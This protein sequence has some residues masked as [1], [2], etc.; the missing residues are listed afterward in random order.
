MDKFNSGNFN[1]RN[2]IPQNP[3]IRRANLGKGLVPQ[4]PLKMPNSP[5]IQ[6]RPYIRGNFPNLFSLKMNSLANVERSLYVK[7]LMNMPKEMKEVL[8]I[9]QNNQ[10]NVATKEVAKLLGTNISISTLADFMQKNGKEAMT[11]LISAM[12]EA[13]RQGVS[14]LSQIKDA[15]K[16]INASVS[17]AGQEN[18]TQ[19]L[20]NFMLLYLPWLPL[21]EGVDFDLEI[22]Q[23]DGE[24]GEEDE[25]ILTIMI[26]T[27][28]FGNIKITLLLEGMNSFEILIKCSETFP[29]EELLKRI[30]EENKTHSFQS[31]VTFEK[32]EEKSDE[33][34]PTQAKVNISNP[35][36]VNPFLL[37]MANAIIRHTIDLDNSAE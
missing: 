24:N 26:S 23:K 25:T 3:M 29:K 35:K 12:A 5:L 30:N 21:Q 36:A 34:H 7:D 4:S 14:D 31:N 16:Y 2:P 17:A 27:K 10:A 9:L 6:P 1:N 13:S 33:I 15:I 32:K 20:K 37:L 18:Q 8:T 28:N 22:E 11:K 19:V